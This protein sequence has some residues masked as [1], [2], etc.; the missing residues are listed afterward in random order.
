MSTAGCDIVVSSSDEESAPEDNSE[1]S[2]GLALSPSSGL[3]QRSDWDE[4]SLDD[5]AVEQPMSSSTRDA[6]M[7]PYV[8]AQLAEEV[9]Y[10]REAWSGFCS[11]QTTQMPPEIRR[12]M[13]EER[14]Y[15]QEAWSEHCAGQQSLM[16]ADIR[17]QLEDEL[18]CLR[19]GWS[20]SVTSLHM[21]GGGY[22]F[23]AL[24]PAAEASA[25]PR[26]TKWGRCDRCGTP[27]RPVSHSSGPTMGRALLRCCKWW[28]VDSGRRQC[29]FAKAYSGDVTAL[30]KTVRQSMAS[31]RKDVRFHL[32]SNGR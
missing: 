30:P 12:Q 8:Q 6:S 23:K 14:L 26:R 2:L 25:Q 18:A 7:P 28:T 9:E 5:V 16:P 22:D 27:L 29:W 17:E 32:Y 20:T 4:A 31:S 10:L 3:S 15:L 13:D 24:R 11:A 1:S 21:S 19:D